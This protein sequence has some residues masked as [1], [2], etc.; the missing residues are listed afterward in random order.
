MIRFYFFQ[1]RSVPFSLST[2]EIKVEQKKVSFGYIY[3]LRRDN[4]LRRCPLLSLVHF[5]GQTDTYFSQY[6]ISIDINIE[7]AQFQLRL[8]FKLIEIKCD[9]NVC[10]HFGFIHLHKNQLGNVIDPAM[11]L[12]EAWVINYDSLQLYQNVNISFHR[13][14]YK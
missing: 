12:L 11:I 3:E 2:I 8:C 6:I 4:E 1:F 9:I 13:V 14:L 5:T 7:Y 10:I